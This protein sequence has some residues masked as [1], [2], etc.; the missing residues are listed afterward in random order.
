[1]DLSGSLERSL[2][3]HLA[4]KRKGTKGNVYEN[5]EEETILTHR[6]LCKVIR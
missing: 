3:P 1:M 4:N 6:L 2:Q 5:Q